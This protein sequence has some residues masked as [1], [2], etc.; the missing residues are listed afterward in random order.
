AVEL[1]PDADYDL[2]VTASPAGDPSADGV[3]IARCHFH[4]SRYKNPSELLAALEVATPAFPY[5]PHDMPVTALP[6]GVVLDDDRALEDALVT[7]GLD[8]WPL[9]DQP[10][11]VLLWKLDGGWKLAGAL[12][13]APEPIGRAG[14]VESVALKAGATTLVPVRRNQA[15]TRAL[16]LAPAPVALAPDAALSLQLVDKT[17]TATTTRSGAR[18]LAGGLPR[19]V[20]EEA[21]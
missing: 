20:T 9:S 2:L 5:A 8:P 4:T 19:F 14:R 15:G 3:V 16:W 13:E 7:L 11:T 17:Q 12:V 6:A 21:P 1:E 10:R 18:R